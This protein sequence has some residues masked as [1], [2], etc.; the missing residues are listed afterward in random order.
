MRL[1][2]KS[3][4]GFTL[5]ELILSLAI[6]AVLMGALTGVVGRV[7][8]VKDDTQL[9]NNTMREARFAM[10]RMVTAVRQ[11]DRLMLPLA[12]NPNTNWRENVREQSVPP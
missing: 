4:Y 3:Q 9:R 2:K 11:S 12:D 1:K 7:L 6:A 5:L 10:Q 8:E